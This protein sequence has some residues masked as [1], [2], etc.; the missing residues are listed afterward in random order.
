MTKHSKYENERRA[1]EDARMK[2]IE[3]A[4]IGSVPA[5]TM[6][7]FTRSVEAARQRPPAGP[8][9]NMAPGTRPN[10]PRVEPRPTK[11]ERPRRSSRS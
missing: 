2:E 7:S 3:A 1:A 6:K 4:W 10:P 11:E 8:P 5:E 9:P